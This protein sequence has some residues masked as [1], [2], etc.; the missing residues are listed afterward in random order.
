MRRENFA[1]IVVIRLLEV[2]TVVISLRL[3]D[4]EDLK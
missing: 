2:P 3:T 1:I 4:R